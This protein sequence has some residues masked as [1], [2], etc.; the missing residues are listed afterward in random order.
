MAVLANKRI[1]LLILAAN[2]RCRLFTLPA[3][4]LTLFANSSP[5]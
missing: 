5:T 1:R 3:N 2:T 4:V